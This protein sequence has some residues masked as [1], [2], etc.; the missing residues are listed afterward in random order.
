MIR[1]READY[2]IEASES[3]INPLMFA[4][5]GGSATLYAGHWAPFLPSEP[6]P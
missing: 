5:V 3:D 4:G 1:E 2:P 6:M